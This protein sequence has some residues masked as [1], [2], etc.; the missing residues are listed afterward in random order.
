MDD[1]F[2]NLIYI[3]ITI[4]AFA[5]S[6]LG[7]K[8]KKDTQRISPVGNE[9][10]FQEKSNPFFA[11]LEQL[12]NEELGIPDQKIQ[13]QYIEDP[14]YTEEPKPKAEEVLDFVPPE[15][16][17]EIEDVPYSIEYDDREEISSSS[18]K[19]ADITSEEEEESIIEGFNLRDAVIY[20]EIMNRREY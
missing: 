12:L 9:K 10:P 14:V 16:L 8:K 19:D 13:N 7:K 6:A 15:M 2:D 1:I 18:I 11:N 3:I 20:S 4:V 17:D 5:I